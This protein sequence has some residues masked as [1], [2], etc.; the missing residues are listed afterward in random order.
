DELT[1]ITNFAG[2]PFESLAV[3]ETSLWAEDRWAPSSR[4]SFTLGLRYDWTTLSRRNEWSPRL[5]FVLLPLRHTV[6]RGGV[7][8]FY[9]IMP[10]TA[11]TFTSG[12]QRVVQFFAQ[13]VPTSEPRTL[14]NVTSREHLRTSS[15]L[16]WNFEIDQEVSGSL[17]LRAKAEERRGRN[18]LVVRPNLTAPRTTAMVLSDQGKSRYRELETTA[19]YRLRRASTLNFSYIR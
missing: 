11:G 17:F 4:A 7:G 3:N 12:R 15:V 19:A 16:G 14:N 10:L 8:V 2:S 5:G 18:V 9:D 6:I 1:S 13:S